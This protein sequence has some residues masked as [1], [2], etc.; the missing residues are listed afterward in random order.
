MFAESYKRSNP[1]QRGRFNI[2]EKFVLA[3]CESASIATTTGTV[4]FDPDQGRI[5]KPDEKRQRGSVF[6][7]RIKM[8]AQEFTEVSDYLRSLLLPAGVTVTFNAEKLIPRSPIQ[9]F[10]ASLETVVIGENGAMRPTVRKTEVGLF[11]VL[12]GEVAHIYELGLPIVET[13]DKWHINVGQKVPLSKDRNNV[14]PRYLKTVRTLV[15]NEMYDRLTKTDAN[16]DWVRQASSSSD[17][18]EAAIKQVLDLRFGE[19][20]AA[21]DPNDKE[22][23]KRW[24]SEGG[25]LV[26]GPMLS[27][28]EWANAKK[29]GAIQPAG[30]LR[31]SPKPYSQE[32]DAENVQVI[33][34]DKWTP[35]MKMVAEYAVFLGRELMDV[36]VTVTFVNTANNFVACYAA[37]GDLHFNVFRLGYAWFDK[38]LTEGVDEL[39]LHEFGHQYSADHLSEQYH[40]GLTRLGAKLKTLALQKPEAFCQ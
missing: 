27:P 23:G 17:C 13:N 39:L 19:M 3:V 22:A 31:P 25:T 1:Q 34:P 10:T 38:G 9:T 40:D 21:F 20:R 6:K 14:P 16:E 35:G 18:S 37:G 33:P 15:L 4:L 7:G 30:K 26:Y 24:V 28:Q 12:P 36:N 29:A 2:G 5:E 11:E 32:K 8:T